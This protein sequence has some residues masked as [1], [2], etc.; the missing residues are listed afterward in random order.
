MRAPKLTPLE[1]F[2]YLLSLGLFSEQILC[3]VK[4]NKL[5]LLPPLSMTR[6]L[7]VCNITNAIVSWSVLRWVVHR[8]VQL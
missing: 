8:S 1:I 3:E 6:L 5:P 7:F 2:Y 4:M